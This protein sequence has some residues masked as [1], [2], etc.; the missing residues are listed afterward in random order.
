MS[1]NDRDHIADPAPGEETGP[2]TSA[3]G[4]TDNQPDRNRRYRFEVDESESGKRILIIDEAVTRLTIREITKQLG[5]QAI[6]AA[7]GVEGVALAKHYQP[8]LIV[9]DVHMAEK[10][11]VQALI[12]IREDE[13]LA[14][15]PIIMLTVD[16]SRKVFTD[17]MHHKA[18][19]YLVKPVSNEILRDRIQKHIS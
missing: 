3:P 14:H 13:R 4:D 1:E 8:D 12:E 16:S 11:G 7:D 6:E 15:T 10:S 9:L 5:R 18:D 19:D 2:S 17:A